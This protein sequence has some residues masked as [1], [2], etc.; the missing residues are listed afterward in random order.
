M[1]ETESQYR[2]LLIILAV[3]L[4]VGST[5]F[6]F[7]LMLPILDS[8]TRIYAAFWADPDPIG[9]AYF[10]GTSIRRIGAFILAIGALIGIIGGA[11]FHFKYF[12]TPNSW[13][14]FFLTYAVLFTLFLFTRFF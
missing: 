11:E 9:Q 4:W 12:N 14:L 8:I 10:L 7:S 1:T 2:K 5:M 6:V 3:F 13:R